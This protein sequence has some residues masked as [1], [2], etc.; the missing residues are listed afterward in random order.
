MQSACVHSLGSLP[1]HG[2]FASSHLCSYGQDVAQLGVT[3]LGRETFKSPAPGRLPGRLISEVG[4][5]LIDPLGDRPQEKTWHRTRRPQSRKPRPQGPVTHPTASASRWS[6]SSGGWSAGRGGVQRFQVDAK[7]TGARLL[8]RPRPL[9]PQGGGEAG[10][11]DRLEA[12]LPAPSPARTACG[13]ACEPQRHR[14]IELRRRTRRGAGFIAHVSA[15]FHASTVRASAGNCGTSGRPRPRRPQLRP[16]AQAAR[17][18]REKPG[19][20][21]FI[22]TSRSSAAIPDGGGWRPTAASAEATPEERARHRGRAGAMCTPPVDDRT[23]SAVGYSEIGYTNATGFTAG[24]TVGFWRRAAAIGFRMPSRGSPARGCSPTTAP[25]T[26]P[27]TS[28]PALKD[29][30]KAQPRRRTRPCAPDQRRVL[31]RFWHP[32]SRNDRRTLRDW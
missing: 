12:V 20:L 18:E 24:L 23:R 21:V 17:Y 7:T 15:A 13:P 30:R 5:G 25:A 27:K 26:A 19:E 29:T 9:A 10:M 22:S 16:A 31:E 3:R 8:A 14:V 32:Q 2:W 4:A 11:G 6:A 28:S 1:E